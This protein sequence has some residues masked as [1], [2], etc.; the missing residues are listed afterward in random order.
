MFPNLGPCAHL[1]CIC[2]FIQLPDSPV[3]NSLIIPLVFT[4]HHSVRPWLFP[5]H[6]MVPL[7]LLP[8]LLNSFQH[9]CF[10]WTSNCLLDLTVSLVPTTACL[11]TLPPVIPIYVAKRSDAN[12][13]WPIHSPQ[14]PLEPSRSYYLTI[15]DSWWSLIY[16]FDHPLLI[17]MKSTTFTVDILV[18]CNT[19]WH[20]T[21]CTFHNV[22]EL[23]TI[24]TPK[25]GVKE[26]QINR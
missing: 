5:D 1:S 4:V 10:L 8:V 21:K 13:C 23:Y 16:D 11:Q 17:C 24:C 15:L 14:P 2:F 6:Y 26:K 12:I 22:L 19:F 25:L 18:P 3:A 20:Q 7:L 9:L